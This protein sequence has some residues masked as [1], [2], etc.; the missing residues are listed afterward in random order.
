MPW[1]GFINAPK[2][3]SWVNYTSDNFVQ[4]TTR[5]LTAITSH[6]FKP[7]YYI[8][9]IVSMLMK[10]IL[11]AINMIRIYFYYLRNKLMKII[12]YIIARLVNITIPLQILLIIDLEISYS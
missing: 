5:I 7:Y 4:C 12:E 8:S 11:H 1:A 9:D 2:G 10:H 6:F 3:T